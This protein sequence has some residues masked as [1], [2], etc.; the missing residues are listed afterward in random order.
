MTKTKA[1]LGLVT[2]YHQTGSISETARRWRTSRQV[3]RKWVR[4]YEA[5]GISGLRDRPHRPHH[6]P[7]QT[8]AEIEDQVLQAWDEIHYGRDRLALYLRAHGLCPS[9]HT[10]CHIFRRRRPPQKRK[11][12]KALYPAM[13]AWDQEEPFSLLQTDVKDIH[14]PYGVYMISK[15]WE[16]RERPICAVNAC[17]ATSGP[18]VTAV[19]ACGSRVAMPT[20]WPTAIA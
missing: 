10:I 18:P 7:R 12:R 3:V 5:E 14:A 4:R 20:A 11:R 1:R 6:S 15:H 2:T 16:R 8:P 13:W 9:P 19:R 17:H